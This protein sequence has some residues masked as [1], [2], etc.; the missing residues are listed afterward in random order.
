MNESYLNRM[1]FN[2]MGS[3]V[4]YSHLNLLSGDLRFSITSNCN[5]RCRYCHREGG[6][7]E[8]ELPY[9]DVLR[10]VDQAM[11]YGLRRVRLTGGEATLHKDIIK[12][13]REI[14]LRFPNIAL[15]MTSNG[16]KI[17]VL[18]QLITEGL[19]DL[20]VVGVDYYDAPVSKDSPIGRPSSEILGNILKMKNVGG[21]VSLTS[22]FDNNL[23]NVEQFIEW[24]INNDI[25]YV[26]F[27]EIINDEVAEQPCIGY[28]NMMEHVINK[29]EAKL[30]YNDT[31]GHYFAVLPN[32]NY[33]NFF[34]SLCRMR[35]CNS[36]A[37]AFMRVSCDGKIVSCLQPGTPVFS[38]L[39]ENDFKE[40]FRA[41][42]SYLGTPPPEALD[43][44]RI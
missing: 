43:I 25:H 16:T 39:G 32:S 23:H 1:W 38:L 8:N 37:R 14:K 20:V 17:D 42:L 6:R 41:G 13:C 3:K 7:V 29:Y 11:V 24:G 4:K 19:L 28:Q 22:V 40:N 12:I 27:L 15:E 5:L 34:H 35:Q 2:K 9:A 26:N 33:I 31:R 18:L 30:T 10:I 36:C 44:E 21:N